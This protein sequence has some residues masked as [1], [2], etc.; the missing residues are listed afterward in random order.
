MLVPSRPE[1]NILVHAGI[2]H[3]AGII[4]NILGHNSINLDLATNYYLC[5]CLMTFDSSQHCIELL[6]HAVL[7]KLNTTQKSSCL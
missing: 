1:P 3:N 4:G 6:S 2:E 7:S 5:E